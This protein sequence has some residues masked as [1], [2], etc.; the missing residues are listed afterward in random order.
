MRRIS[1]ACAWLLI[2]S[3][4]AYQVLLSPWL[5]RRCRHLPSCSAYAIEAIRRFGPLRGGWLAAR[6]L[7][8]CHPWGTSGYD[9][10]PGA[11]ADDGP[12]GKPSR[13]E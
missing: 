5:G 7:G 9:P 8:R 6:R 11:S 12:R 10:V 1:A 2:G 4:R 13:G 3:V